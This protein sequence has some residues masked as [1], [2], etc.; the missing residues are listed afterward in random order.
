MATTPTT[1]QKPADPHPAGKPADNATKPEPPKPL[2]V[3][4]AAEL[5]R[6]GSRLAK[7]GDPPEKWFSM[8]R[9]PDGTAVLQEPLSDAKLEEVKK[10]S[11]Y[12]VEDQG[13]YHIPPPAPPPASEPAPAKGT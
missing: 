8:G 11:Y 3:E 5:F 10:G 4:D 2:K 13:S 9:T 12:L 6:S 7:M 1:P